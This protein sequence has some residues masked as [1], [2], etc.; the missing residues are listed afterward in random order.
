MKQKQAICLYSKQE[1]LVKELNVRPSCV[2]K[3]SPSLRNEKLIKYRDSVNIFRD[4]Y[5]L[6][7][8]LINEG[9]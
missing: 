9:N 1:E 3:Y 4:I 2:I 5:I 6:T 8:K 7:S